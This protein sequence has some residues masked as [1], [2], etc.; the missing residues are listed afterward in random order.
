MNAL[1][2]FVECDISVPKIVI[3][4]SGITQKVS[5]SPMGVPI[6]AKVFPIGAYWYPHWENWVSIRIKYLPIG[7]RKLTLIP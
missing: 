2:E 7:V 1:F 5:L 6:G 4:T 3:M